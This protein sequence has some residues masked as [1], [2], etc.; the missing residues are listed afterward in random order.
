VAEPVTEIELE[1]P[2][3]E[4]VTVSVAVMVCTPGVFRVAEEFP[5]PFVSFESAG[6]TAWP[7]VL[8]KCT[9]PE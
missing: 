2:V 4:A 3:M 9:V 8:V 7:S 6:R 5:T 1:V